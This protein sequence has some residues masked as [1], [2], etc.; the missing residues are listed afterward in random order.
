M[1][2]Q[3][4][5]FLFV[6]KKIQ[7][8]SRSKPKKG[9]YVPVV[10]IGAS[11]GGLEAITLLLRNLSPTTGMAFVY[12]QHLSPT[13]ES[14]L[15]TLLSKE[16]PMKVLEAK[17]R[18]PIRP[19][20]FY[21]I[22]AGKTTKAVNGSLQLTSRKSA[23]FPIDDF[24]F[25]LA[26]KREEKAIGIVLSGSASDGTRGLKAIKMKGGLTFAQDKSASF[27]SM[28]NSAIAEGVV[29]F[30]LSPEEMGR[31]MPKIILHAFNHPIN[32]KDSK[33]EID[34]RD[35][36]L[37]NILQMLL[38]ESG[39][40]FSHYKMTTVKRRILRRLWLHK[41]KNL[42][43]Y[44]A[45]LKKKDNE[46]QQLYQDLL[47]H[48]TSFFRD[49]KAIQ[50][51][52]EIILPRLLKNKSK[53]DPLRIWVPACSSGEEA[54]SLAI[55]FWE[56]ADDN[57]YRGAIQI[58]ATDLSDS[59]IAKARAGEYSASDLDTVS[60]ERL[61][62]FFTKSDG[63]YLINKSIRDLC[64]FA[65]HNIFRD[66]PFSRIDLISCCNLLIYLDPILQSR[67]L[68]AF[69][70]SLNENGYLMLGRSETANAAQPLFSQVNKKLRIYTR[71]QTGRGQPYINLNR[72]HK[73]PLNIPLPLLPE[74]KKVPE[75]VGL[76][77][78]VD[79]LLLSR[80]IPACVVINHSMEIVQFRGSTSQFLQPSPG[81]A[82]LN[83]LKM[84]H[85]ALTYDLRSAIIKAKKSGL[86]VRQIGIDITING[87]HFSASFEVVPLKSQE[88]E[89]FMV[90]LFK[91]EAKGN[92]R[93]VGPQPSSVKDKRITKLEAELAVARKEMQTYVDE[94]EAANEEL[95]SA[96]EEI[97]SSNEELQSINEELE[98]SKE[99]IE[100]TNEELLAT[101]QEL[102]LRNEQVAEAFHFSEAVI[103]TLHEPLIILDSAMRVRTANRA[104]YKTFHVTQKNTEGNIFFELGNKQ[105][106]IPA[107]SELL[108]KV[109]STNTEFTEFEVTHHFPVIGL[110]SMLLN[111]RRILQKSQNKQ[112]I[113]LAIQDITET[114]LKTRA[115][116]SA[117][118][119]LKR[120]NTDLEQ[121]AYVASHDLQEPLRKIS[122]FSERL[123]NALKDTLTSQ[124]KEYLLRMS[125]SSKKMS[126][127]VDELLNY[128]HVSSGKGEFI[129]V[130]LNKTMKEVLKNFDLNIAESNAKISVGDLPTIKAVPVEM[131]QL[132][133]NLISNALKFSDDS[134]KPEIEV[135]SKILDTKS[136]PEK[137]N[138]ARH[139]L[140]GKPLRYYEICVRDN[141]I[142]FD[143]Q[144]VE[145]I[146]TIFKRLHDKKSTSGTGIGLALCRKI[147]TN[148][149]GVI[150]ARSTSRTGSEFHV[151]LPE[152]QLSEF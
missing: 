69:H 85:P 151:I 53:N 3:P 72:R 131:Y 143:E 97:V 1:T 67:A 141:G 93:D 135:T 124:A 65:P 127:L 130:N 33:S 94:Q 45:V 21:I 128:S 57:I 101:N 26:E 89:P 77:E 99:E 55:A 75:S 105:W 114:K 100:S 107:L 138:L 48:V 137:L 134:R 132:F 11:A 37:K 83:L 64:V 103:T 79:A 71:K 146:F 112:L 149:G 102:Q 90:V 78:S 119:D 18:M 24:F 16:T 23:R 68:Q 59:A 60:P 115:L 2:F 35:P 109:I 121:F 12:F 61:R 44:V 15:P 20:C 39:V 110:K 49:K 46:V 7:K 116:E 142:G 36:G 145:D 17:N 47:I 9:N 38:K 111:G 152:K 4:A 28:P 81:K 106:D 133:Q 73:A 117:I 30:I 29:D 40:D 27:T 140:S 118:S 86:A 113:L 74:N 84:V 123:E 58:F 82:S 5:A 19:N 120:S 54:Y 62:R 32:K 108:N 50:Y 87:K 52:K 144:Q 56:A 98:T 136:I 41:L 80:Y 92:T 66:P 76:D 6:M 31:E 129:N 147:A 51:F 88:S 34:N 126:N 104:F 22:P 139:A 96:N 25:S 42:N 91:K 148:H 95:Q 122:I 14:L 63:K 8:V 70:Y 150:Y 125:E 13:H 10:G 43:E